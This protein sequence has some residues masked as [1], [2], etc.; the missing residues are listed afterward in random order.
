MYECYD[1]VYTGP[2]WLVI[3]GVFASNVGQ[4]QLASG[5]PSGMMVSKWK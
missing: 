1:A 4:R 5:V 3:S 2:W